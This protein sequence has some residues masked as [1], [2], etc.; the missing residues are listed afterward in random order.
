MNAH[1]LSLDY[2]EAIQNK[3]DAEREIKRLRGQSVTAGHEFSV[4]AGQKFDRIVEQ[5][6]GGGNG[7]SV[8]AFVERAT[9]R[10]VK[11]AG[12]PAPAKKSNGELQSKYDLSTPEGF[13]E[14]VYNADPFGS[15][16]YADYPVKSVA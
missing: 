14:A 9:G 16:L 4:M 3:F 12:W 15:Y 1:P 5:Y 7:K 10:L 6:R 11:A 13:R 2:A 8:H